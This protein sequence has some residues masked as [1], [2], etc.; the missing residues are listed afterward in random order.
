ML[1]EEEMIAMVSRNRGDGG[2]IARWLEMHVPQ[3]AWKNG[4]E[5]LA[6]RG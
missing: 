5:N 6:D 4:I 3:I 2:Y 1:E